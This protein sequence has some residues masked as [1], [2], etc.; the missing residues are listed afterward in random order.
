[1][2]SFW[3]VY[4]LFFYQDKKLYIGY[5]KDLRRRIKEHRN[6]KTVSVK[7]RGKFNLIYYEALPTKSEAM[8]REKFYKGGRGHEVILKILFDTLPKLRLGKKFV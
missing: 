2:I 1:M 8:K 6:G 4:V 3:Y 5:T 7:S